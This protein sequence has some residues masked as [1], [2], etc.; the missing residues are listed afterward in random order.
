[1]IN[2]RQILCVQRRIFHSCARIFHFVEVKEH[3]FSAPMLFSIIGV[4]R[5][6]API[7]G[8]VA[9]SDDEPPRTSLEAA[10]P[11]QFLR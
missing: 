10:P 5:R 1:M 9:A 3:A 7:I 4:R 6:Q 8:L 11:T 2:H